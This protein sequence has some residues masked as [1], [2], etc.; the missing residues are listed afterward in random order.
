MSEIKFSMPPGVV[1][2]IEHGASA[3]K[4]HGYPDMQVSIVGGEVVNM[5]LF[6]RDGRQHYV[7]CSKKGVWLEHLGIGG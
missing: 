4:T 1:S 2:A 5:S 7:T 6:D 3:A